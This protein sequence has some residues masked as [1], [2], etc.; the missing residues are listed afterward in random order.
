M[1][2]DDPLN[3]FLMEELLKAKSLE[4]DSCFGGEMAITM[5]RNSI[6]K[7]AEGTGEHYKLILMDYSMP[8]MDGPTAVREILRLYR[9]SPFVT[10]NQV[11]YICCCTA[12]NDKKFKKAALDAGMNH[13]LTKPISMQ[14]IEQILNRLD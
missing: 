7:F 3:I 14:Y 4:C 10:E 12:Y 8:E 2:D 11:P 5:V 6:L 1:V 9:E 13:L